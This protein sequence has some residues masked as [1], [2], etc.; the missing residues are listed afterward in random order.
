[1]LWFH[2]TSGARLSLRGAAPLVGGIVLTI[3][4]SHDPGATLEAVAHHLTTLEHPGS[5]APLFALALCTGLALF[6]ERH[7]AP[8]VRGWLRSLPLSGRSHSRSLLLALV[9]S[10]APLL[11]G[12]LI[13]WLFGFASGVNVSWLRLGSI[14]LT[15]FAAALIALVITGGGAGR[16]KPSRIT[17]WR[18]GTGFSAAI[19]PA[20]VTL[21]ALGRRWTGGYL[22]AA[23]PLVALHLF[24]RNNPLPE[25]L[26]D[27]AGRFAAGTAAAWLIIRFVGLLSVRRPPWPWL[28]SQPL[29]ASRR[30][31]WD[32]LFLLGHIVPLLAAAWFLA[33]LSSGSVLALLLFAILLA[34]RGA[35]ALRQQSDTPLGSVGPI[36]FEGFFLAAW[37]GVTSYSAVLWLVL[38]PLAWR[39]AVRREQGAGVY[40]WVERH[41]SAAG[42]SMSWSD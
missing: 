16:Q 1:M 37:T 36:L 24:I 14:I 32:A 10:Q 22:R 20:I 40:R 18:Y 5:P 11:G 9:A 2:I 38:I 21:R 8:G 19:L 7:L 31:A 12:W 3:G 23:I 34:I 27:G 39:S 15:G 13:L 4:M 42:D 17:W 35:G 29:K 41:H 30:V 6:A 25:Q 26:L 28:R 33:P